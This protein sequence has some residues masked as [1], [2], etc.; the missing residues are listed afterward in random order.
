MV[1]VLTFC[2]L[3][4]GVAATCFAGVQNYSGAFACR[5]FIGL[6]G[7]F[8]FLTQVGSPTAA[9]TSTEAGF[10]PL[11]QV[12]LSR[13][14]AREKLGTRVAVWLAMAPLG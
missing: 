5:F 12:F 1:S 4:W 2:A 10:S 6:G 9:N 13:F 3:L 8:F 11:I 7:K 14:Y